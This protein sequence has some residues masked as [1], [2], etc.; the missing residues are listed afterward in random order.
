MMRTFIMIDLT[1]NY[2]LKLR[3][4]TACLFSERFY[5][6]DFIGEY[7]N[8]LSSDIEA[9]ERLFNNR[10]ERIINDVNI[11]NSEVEEPETISKPTK[12]KPKRK[13]KKKQPKQSHTLDEFLAMED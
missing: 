13:T 10:L 1:S 5:N 11:Y 2:E 8:H 12:E 7:N 9:I 3:V 4:I 6:M